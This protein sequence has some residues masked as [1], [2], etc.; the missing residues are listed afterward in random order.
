MCVLSSISAQYQLPFNVIKDNLEKNMK[1]RFLQ[2][3]NRIKRSGRLLSQF[4]V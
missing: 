1:D 2:L 3:Q 4:I